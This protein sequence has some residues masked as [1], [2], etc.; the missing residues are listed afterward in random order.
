MLTA[1]DSKKI[2]C[3][4]NLKIS[5]SCEFSKILIEHIVIRAH[6]DKMLKMGLD[7]S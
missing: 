6:F 4:F 1:A 2:S 5:S 3:T 7:R